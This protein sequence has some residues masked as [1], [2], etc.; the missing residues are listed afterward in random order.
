MSAACFW[1]RSATR[2]SFV[3]RADSVELE[4]V[5]EGL[6]AEGRVV[7][8]R[9]GEIEEL[10]VLGLRPGDRDAVLLCQLLKLLDREAA[11]LR[12][13]AALERRLEELLLLRLRRGLLLDRLRRKETRRPTSGLLRDGLERGSANDERLGHHVGA[14]AIRMGRLGRE[15]FLRE[16]L[17]IER[18]A[19]GADP[20]VLGGQPLERLD[21]DQPVELP[22]SLVVGPE[23]FRPGDDLHPVLGL[24]EDLRAGVAERLRILHD[25]AEVPHEV[26][27]PLPGRDPG[28]D[29]PLDAVGQLPVDPAQEDEVVTRQEVERRGVDDR[30]GPGRQLLDSVG[31]EVPVERELG[32]GELPDAGVDALAKGL[33]SGLS[34]PEGLLGFECR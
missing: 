11:E 16:H 1:A 6:T 33:P 8:A 25:P 20:L 19:H 5:R 10:Q 23:R 3:R 34:E 18:T 15:G 31:G 26:V 9:L 17:P 7:D 28:E 12:R 14:A 27:R 22:A 29:R 21:A 30:E 2:S 13:L 24:R 4:L 32:L